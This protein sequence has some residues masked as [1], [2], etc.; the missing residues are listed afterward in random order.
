[1]S[2]CLSRLFFFR[3]AKNVALVFVLASMASMALASEKPSVTV[4]ILPQKYFVEK[5]AGD[6]LRVNV[7]VAPG[8]SP[9]NYEPTPSQLVELS[10]SRIF[11]SIGVPFERVW[12]PRFSETYP[13]LVMVAT[14]A[15][16]A[17][18]PIADHH[19]HDDHGHK[20]HHHGEDF[21]DPHIWL[22]PELVLQQ[23]F[24][25][26]EGLK[27]VFPEYAEV[28]DEGHA[29]FVEKIQAL[30]ADIRKLL[31][32]KAG[33]A[34]FVFHPSWGYFAHAYG[35]EQIPVE[36]GGREPTPRELSRLIRMAKDKKAAAIFI[37]PQFSERAAKILAESVQAEVIT[38]DPL[39]ENWPDNL[40]KA[41][42]VLSRHLR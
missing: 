22:A 31:A 5:L 17:K 25:I 36:V 27:K 23:I 20:G 3:I 1:M 39:A 41:A 38:M 4:S 19:H 29:L 16:I 37:Q 13:R 34:F 6:L 26:R 9:H 33:T 24:T 30:D 28:F 21:P 35:L 12:M 15:G 7:M 40:L 18:R 10:R 11:F 32:P 2:L 14:D 42:G 8:S